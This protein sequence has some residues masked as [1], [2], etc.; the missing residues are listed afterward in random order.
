V[1]RYAYDTSDRLAAV[2]DGMGR[3]TV[4]G[5]DALS[6]RIAV[7]NAGIQS[8][9]LLQQTYTPDGLVGSLTDANNNT[10]SFTPDGFDRL[11]TTT[12]PDSSTENLSY[13][14]DSN[15]LTRQTRAGPTITFTYDTLNR[16][17]SKAAPAEPTVTYGYDLAGRAT[18]VTD[19]SAAIVAPSGPV[20]YATNFAY[21]ALN[22]PTNITWSP[23][24]AAVTPTASGVTFSHSYN[25]ANQRSGQGTTDNTWFNYPAAAGP[26]SY[27]ANNLNQYTAVNAVTPSY[28]GNGNLTFDGT[29]TYC[30]DAENRMTAVLSAGT[31]A[32]PTTTVATYA[33]DAQRRRKSKTVGGVTTMFVTD[34]D[35][36]EVME[37]DGSSGAVQNW[38]AYGLGPNAVLNQMGVATAARTTFVPDI[39][40]STIGSLDAASGTLTKVAYGVYGEG[41]TSGSFR[42]TGQRI[43]PETNGLYYYRARHY[44]PAWGRFM[45]V[46]PVGYK[47]GS[48]LYIYSGN[49]P[50]N[51]TDPLGLE[52]VVIITRDAVPYTFGLLTYGSHAAVRVDNGNSPVLY[53]PAGSYLSTTRGSGDALNGEQANLQAYIQYQQSTGSTV[54]IYRFQTTLGQEA[55]IASRIDELGGVI[56]CFCATG[57]SNAIGGIGPFQNVGSFFPGTLETQL[58]QVLK[59]NSGSGQT[60]SSSAPNQDSNQQTQNIN[61]TPQQAA[62]QQ[63]DLG[64][65]A[66]SSSPYSAPSAK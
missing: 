36:R 47:A 21:D 46:D 13:D 10:T 39:L 52:T 57:V 60:P 1:T 6:R 45:Q 66:P 19:N 58:Q 12:Y 30:Y 27:T 55:D 28:D 56:P 11:A 65:D 63:P 35:N 29:F 33:Y 62:Q 5:Y 51:G 15:V 53:D 54:N 18:S 61:Y 26:V 38:Y 64:M 17:G 48:N 23:A 43:D 16:L 40:G 8:A 25:N 9:P 50:L 49:D 32:A 44:M 41:A 24:L 59:Q 22:R 34:A 31:C 14:A 4:F 42:Y 3:T 37:Y 20:V 2:T 7:S